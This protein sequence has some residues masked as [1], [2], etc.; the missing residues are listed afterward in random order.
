MLTVDLSVADLIPRLATRHRVIAV[1]LQ[2]HGHTADAER[3]IS[4]ATS[5]ADVV[6]LLDHLGIERAHVL[7]RSMGGAAAMEL[8]VNHRDRVLPAVPISI[9]VRAGGMHAD[10]SDPEAMAT[11]ARMPTGEDLEGWS[12]EQL[13]AVSIP[14]L[15]VIGDHDVTTLEHAGQVLD[16]TPGSKP[17]ELPDTTHVQAT[18]RVTILDPALA[19]LLAASR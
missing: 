5:A 3:T 14:V 11:S 4:P 19:S 7:G 16:R 2:G 6:A 1:E 13:A 10:F 17:L 9:T 15:F 18:H 12:D 8:A